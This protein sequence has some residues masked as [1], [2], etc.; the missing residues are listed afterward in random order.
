M[1]KH[2]SFGDAV[3]DAERWAFKLLADELPNDYLLLTNI[4][5][6]TQSGQAMEVDALV[7]G[8]WGIYVVDVKGYIGRLD[9]GL[10][11]W[12][13]DGREVDNSLSKANYV[14]RVLAGRLK[15]KIPVGVYA[16]WCQGMVFVT[17]R[18]GEEIR[19]EKQS[20]KLSVYT[21]EVI[22]SALTKEWGL[23]AQHKH[24]V[25]DKQKQFVLDTIGQ[26]AL[27]EQRNNRIQDFVKRKC[28]FIQ[29]G[30]EVWLADYDP[31][32]WSAHWLLKILIPS[33]FEDSELQRRHEQQLSKEFVRLQKLAGCS[34]VPYCA[35]LIHDGEQVVLPVRLPMGEPFNEFNVDQCDALTLLRILRSALTSLQQIHRRGITVSGW[36]ENCVFVSAEADVEFIDIQDTMTVNEDIQAFA[37][38][39]YPLA[40]KAGQPVIYQWFAKAKRG[41]GVELDGIRSDISIYLEHPEWMS[42]D[43]GEPLQL[44]AGVIIDGHTRLEESLVSYE[45]SELWRATH[46]HGN[47]DCA[48]SI[49]RQASEQWGEVSST[50]RS[51]HYLHHPH[52]EQVMAFGQLP[53]GN[54]I[55]CTRAWVEGR[56]LRDWA[57]DFAP[58]T[59]VRWFCQLL[60]ALQFMHRVDIYHGAICPE[61]VI[62]NHSKAVLVNF[63]LGLNI[64]QANYASRYAD[65]DLWSVEG[66][67]EKDLFGLVAS[68]LDTFSQDGLEGKHSVEELVELAQSLEGDVMTAKLVAACVKVLRFELMVKPG[69]DYLAVFD[70]QDQPFKPV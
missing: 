32:Q 62:C 69:D 34:G 41:E 55:Y 51:L 1:A 31:G 17:G 47:Y 11:A 45:N 19:L 66:A 30:L 6:P 20:D 63:G 54:D 12:Q 43:T 65:P 16:P 50:F 36:R 68:F 9:A 46:I 5:I 25:T 2:I 26:V 4:E 13:L 40:L 42:R 23:T 22:V 56:S 48:I 60:T 33:Q 27:V 3:N 24:Q 14:A 70:L 59:P 37:A 39:F 8:E 57:H 35:P 67:A 28:L 38:L 52:I 15:H 21:P 10:H 49:Y 7:I 58:G 61:N 53:G 44:A 64:A 29:H 18:K